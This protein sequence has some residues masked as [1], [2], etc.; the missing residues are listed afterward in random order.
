MIESGMAAL[1]RNVEE[2]HQVNMGATAI[3]TG[4]NSPPGYA[5]RVAKKLAVTKI[6]HFG[7][8]LNSC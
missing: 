6:C 4:L 2:L 1:K 3:G 5:D 7:T 8:A